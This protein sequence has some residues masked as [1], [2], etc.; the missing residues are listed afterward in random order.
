[1]ARDLYDS[2][3]DLRVSRSESF[4]RHAYILQLE[5]VN[6]KSNGVNQY[7][8]FSRMDEVRHD[9]SQKSFSSHSSLFS[10]FMQDYY[11]LVNQ[12]RG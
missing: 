7:S 5:K 3:E 6:E 10:S 2:C 8:K 11:E 1:M 4:E 12:L 9:I